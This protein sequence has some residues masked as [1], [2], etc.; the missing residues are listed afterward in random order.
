MVI[1]FAGNIGRS[2]IGGKAWANM[3]YLAGL[4]ALG[5]DVVYL[6]DCG[7][8]SWV[9]NWD[10][11]DATTDLAYP[12]AYVRACLEPL[13][14]AKKSIYRAGDRYEGMSPEDLLD[15][16]AGA[17]LLIVWADP[18]SVWRKAYDLPRRRIFI[19]VDPGFTQL[20]LVDGDPQL[21]ETLAH[22]E[23]LFTV[24]ANIGTPGC[25][26]PDNGRPWL[27]T[28][29]PVALAHWPLAANGAAAYFTSVMSWRGFRDVHHE[30]EFYGQ[31]DAEFPKFLDLPRLTSQPLLVAQLVEGEADPLADHGWTTV[32]GRTVSAT[33]AAYQSFI[34]GSRAE[35]GVAKHGYVLTQGGWFSD[36]S[37]CYLAS[38]RPTL[39]QDT[40]LM[41]WIP[42][43][44]GIVP[45]R[46]LTEAVRGIEA[47]NADYEKH[48][49]AARR[50]AEEYFAADVVLPRLLEASLEE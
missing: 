21:Q 26:I 37:V 23:R 22:C 12:A 40:G 4:T 35:F 15:V 29:P 2:G 48:R 31:K 46:D 8:E 30:G 38:G 14:L 39:V 6:E 25:T 3:Q 49:K 45:F 13:G 1:V 10:T 20:A 17:D 28:V 44:E 33:P 50:L 42:T 36:R 43:G 11:D 9:Y 18:L 19:D 7:R 24:G 47:I 32:P 27:K 41:N 34:Q 5:H 16:C